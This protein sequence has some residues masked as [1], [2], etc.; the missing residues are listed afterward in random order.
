[1]EVWDT[2]TGTAALAILDITADDAHAIHNK[3]TAAA[4]AMRTDGDA[5]SVD[6]LR[7]DLATLLLRGHPLPDAIAALVTTAPCAAPGTTTCSDSAHHDVCHQRRRYG[8]DLD[9]AGDHDPE[10][11]ESATIVDAREQSG[12]GIEVPQPARQECHV[13]AGP[14]SSTQTRQERLVLRSRP[15]SPGRPKPQ[16]SGDRQRAG[17]G[18]R[19]DPQPPPA[20]DENHGA[21]GALLGVASRAADDEDRHLVEGVDP[22]QHVVR[23]LATDAERRLSALRARLRATGRLADLPALASQSVRDLHHS[24]VPYRDSWCD[25]DE[26]GRHGHPGYRPPAA[27][28]RMIE[29]RHTTCVFPTCNRRV[30]HCDL[31]H[32]IAY[33][34]HGPTCGC[35]LAPLCR[36]HHRTKQTPGWRLFQPWPGLLVWITPSG[37]WHIVR[38]DRVPAPS[39]VHR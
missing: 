22:P 21:A 18:Q 27:L 36:R 19:G 30:E 35:N 5:R 11:M 17:D 6:Q 16:R 15:Q 37:T 13:I 2:A 26:A 20:Q 33:D 38:P 34:A 39:R 9:R 8:G 1:V 14:I 31:D 29:A 4:A 28:R 23:T 3:I 10:R 25:T 12:S 24:L 7:A 32:T